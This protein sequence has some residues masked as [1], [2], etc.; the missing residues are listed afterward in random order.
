[1]TTEELQTYKKIYLGTM[2]DESVVE[3]NWNTLYHL[4]PPRG[5]TGNNFS[6]PIAYTIALI[7]IFALIGLAHVTHAHNTF[8]AVK[9][10]SK[11]FSATIENI[12]QIK[13]IQPTPIQS[14]PTP[15]SSGLTGV[16][17]K[18]TIQ[19][20]PT[21]TIIPTQ[22]NTTKAQQSTPDTINPPQSNNPGNSN[23]SHTQTNQDVKGTSTQN[24]PIDGKK[25]NSQAENNGKS[26]SQK[27]VSSKH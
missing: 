17:P 25:G 13:H 16:Q 11:S 7:V 21:P 4:L 10:M 6:F 27:S 20:G 26:N 19:S 3:N 8:S 24:N 1:M 15:S 23:G 14:G 2:V 12:F 18:P 5:L 9:S 22:E